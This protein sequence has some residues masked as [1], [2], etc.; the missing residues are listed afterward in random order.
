MWHGLAREIERYQLALSSSVVEIQS[1]RCDLYTQGCLRENCVAIFLNC[2]K[3][4][5]ASPAA[6]G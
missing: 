3:R 5:S 6:A 1:E 2:G 4:V